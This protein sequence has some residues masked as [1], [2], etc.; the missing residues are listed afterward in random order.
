MYPALILNDV[1]VLPDGITEV[2]IP[3]NTVML[4]IS[5]G[6]LESQIGLANIQNVSGDS[7]SLSGLA[8]GASN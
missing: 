3:A 8:V 7:V 1:V 6:N 5:G 2:T 4:L